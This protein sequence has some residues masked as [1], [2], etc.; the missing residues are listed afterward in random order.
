MSAMSDMLGDVLKK[1]LP[2][3]VMAL[4]TPE[5]MQEIGNKANAFIHEMRS[6]LHSIEETQSL[7]LKKLERLE[8]VG[9]DSDYGSSIHRQLPAG[10]ITDNR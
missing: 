1:A 3:E 6:S 9:S 2:P 5:N 10:T 8:N 4:L 7:I